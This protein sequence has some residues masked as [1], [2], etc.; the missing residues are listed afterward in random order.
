[1]IFGAAWFMPISWFTIYGWAEC[2]HFTFVENFLSSTWGFKASH[3]HVI[4]SRWLALAL[5][6]NFG[7][8]LSLSRFWSFSSKS[9]HES[10]FPQKKV[11]RFTQFFLRDLWF[12]FFFSTLLL[13]SSRTRLPE[14]IFLCISHYRRVRMRFLITYLPAKCLEYF[15]NSLQSGFL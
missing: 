6:S 10:T 15:W 5:V 9:L 14:I 2:T 8:I 7:S 3:I 4:K 13:L 12:I 1:M 11:Q